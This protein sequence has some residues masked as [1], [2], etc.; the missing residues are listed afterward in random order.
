MGKIKKK[1]VIRGRRAGTAI[2]NFWAVQEQRKRKLLLLGV[3]T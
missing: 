2:G 3:S 1:R